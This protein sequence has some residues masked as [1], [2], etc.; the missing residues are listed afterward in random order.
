M[1]IYVCIRLRLNHLLIIDQ[2]ILGQLYKINF[3]GQSEGLNILTH[4]IPSP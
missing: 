2:Q 3:E 4:K 1:N